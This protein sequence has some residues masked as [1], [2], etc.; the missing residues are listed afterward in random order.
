MKNKVKIGI[1][2]P[3][4]YPYF[5][6][7]QL[8]NAVDTFVILDDVNFI[9]RGWINRNNI[10]LNNK[11]YLFSLP[12]DKPSQNK[13]INETKLNL[14]IKDRENFLKTIQLAYKKAPFYNNFYPIL[15]S[16]ILFED[17]D[18]VKFIYNS[19]IKTS[20]YINIGTKFI[21]SSTIK[22]KNDLKAEAKIIDICK[23][24]QTSTYI[25]P[26]GGVSLYNK[27]TFEQNGIKLKFIQSNKIEYKQFYNE[28]VPNLSMIDVMMFN[29]VEQ[30]KIILE[31]YELI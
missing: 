14:S 19:L 3:Y 18:I 4:F 28:F 17:E 23:S 16:V 26:I 5:G 20:D 31:R 1:M 11:A 9:M 30:I 29:S 24:T 22:E 21:L 2:Q 8:I 6:Y 27:D 12:L 25:N 10:L 7:W 15:E 13:L